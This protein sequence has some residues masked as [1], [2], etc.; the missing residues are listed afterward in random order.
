MSPISHLS[1]VIVALQPEHII[2]L[3]QQSDSHTSRTYYD[4]DDHR[5][6]MEGL[7]K[8]YEDTLKTVYKH[9]TTITYDVTDVYAFMDGLGDIACLTYVTH[10][11]L[12]N[13][14]HVCVHDRWHGTVVPTLNS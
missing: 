2:V 3:I 4:F 6:M 7:L 10:A 5:Q 9:M 14:T 13:V 12:A 1:L 8:I 11:Q